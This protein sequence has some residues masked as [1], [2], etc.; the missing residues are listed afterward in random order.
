MVLDDSG[1]RYNGRHVPWE[2]MTGLRTDDYTRKG[3]V[4]LE[5]TAGGVTRSL[6][7]DS[8]HVEKFDEIVNAM[9]NPDVKE[10]V[11]KTGA[12]PVGDRPADFEA[13]MANER[14]RLGDVIVRS[15]IVLTE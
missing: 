4:Y 13:F 6:R 2:A 14:Q 9:N 12:V 7:L 3:W 15:K 10:R 5:Y 1:L 8:Y 11:L